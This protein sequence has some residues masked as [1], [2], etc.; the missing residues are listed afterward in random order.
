V[1]DRPADAGR[2]YRHCLRGR[3]PLKRRETNAAARHI[4]AGIA[5]AA[6]RIAD[7]APT[8]ILFGPAAALTA[9]LTAWLAGLR[10]SAAA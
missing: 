6:V 3:E 7:A 2:L 1:P 8:L 5:A 10:W 4:E 9:L